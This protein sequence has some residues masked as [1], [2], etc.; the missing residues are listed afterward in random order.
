MIES[1]NGSKRIMKINIL[2][3]KIYN[4]D[5]KIYDGI[6]QNS[7]NIKHQHGHDNFNQA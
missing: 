3:M 5:M 4:L 1:I 7:I 6:N 2:A